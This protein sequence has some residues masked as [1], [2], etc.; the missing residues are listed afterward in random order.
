MMI[1]ESSIFKD[2]VVA[3]ELSELGEKIGIEAD[4]EINNDEPFNPEDIS[5]QQKN[6]SMGLILRRLKQGTIKL[7]PSFQR[8]EVWTPV[9][10]SHLIESLMLKIPLPMFYVAA[11]GDGVWEV[12]DGLQRLTT[13]RDFFISNADG[14]PLKLSNLEFLGDKFNGKTFLQIENDS[15]EQKWVNSLLETEMQFTIINPGTPESVKRNIFKRI[16]TGGMPL[17]SQEIR[18]ALYGGK[19][20]DLLQE[21]LATKAFQKAIGKQIDDS[22]MGGSEL[23]LR[24]ISFMLFDRTY[25]NTS[26]DTWLS[27]AMQVIN[28]LPD[29]NQKKLQSIF[30]DDKFSQLKI[31]E[32]DLIKKSFIVAMKRSK[33][34]FGKHAFRTSLP[35][36]P[37]KSPINKAL[38]ETWGVILSELSNE[39]FEMLQNKKIDFLKQYKNL[40]KEPKS[41][42]KND[43][44]RYSST[45]KST[46]KRYN[47]IKILV[48]ALIAKDKA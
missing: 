31:G 19:S 3:E 25:Y 29:I 41:S 9:R 33:T 48:G 24:L 20:S 21:L 17:S 16:N 6:I 26:M 2:E 40:M 8:K 27:N 18:N 11:Q 35:G 10:K 32:V 23:I 39:E 37:R 43:I 12:V 34:L 44:S 14:R 38:F 15:K 36:D 7:S 1:E 5:I 22:R 28:C 45:Q 46:Q 13:I 42:F 30:D 47:E 4:A